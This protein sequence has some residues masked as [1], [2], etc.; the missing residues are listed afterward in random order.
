MFR[1]GIKYEPSF[2]LRGAPLYSAVAVPLDDEQSFWK[3]VGDKEDQTEG[4]GDDKG[5][6]RLALERKLNKLLGEKEY[7]V[8]A[9]GIVIKK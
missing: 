6:A 2:P 3:A 5:E 4:V 8:V 9:D 7:E 1:I